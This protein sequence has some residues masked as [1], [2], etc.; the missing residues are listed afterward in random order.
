MSTLFKLQASVGPRDQLI[1]G[2][3]FEMGD[4]F[5]FVDPG[6]PS[7]ETPLHTVEIDTFLLANFESTNAQ[8][9]LFLQDGLR[10]HALRY[11]KGVVRMSA[12]TTIIC[13]THDYASY[14]SIGYT[15]DS[16]ALRDFRA[17]HPVVGVMWTGAALYC[18]WLSTQSKLDTCF[19]TKT[20]TCD[21]SKSGYRLPTE[22]E[23]EYAAR[24]AHTSPY[25]NYP[26]G[27]DRDV[28]K[29]NW[30]NS[31]DPYEIGELPYTT[32]VGFY[33]GSLRRR[34]EFMWLSNLESYQT[35][36]GS[37]SF[38]LF[39]MAGNV[40]EFVYDWYSQ[41]YYAKSPLRNP[42]GPVQGFIMPDGKA[43]RGMRGGNWYNGYTLDS[44]NDGHS[45]VSNRNPSYYRG[46]QDPIHPW[47]HVGFRVARRYTP[48][49]DIADLPDALDQSSQLTL[50]P[51]PS[52]SQLQLRLHL[53]KAETFQLRLF[54]E[55]GLC[56][57]VISE[58]NHPSKN[59]LLTT[60]VDELASGV[61]YCV[62]YTP[63]T[64]VCRKLLVAHP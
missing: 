4:H 1:P 45:R 27:N 38:G 58:E 59:M 32:P 6:H 31:G 19:D 44:I 52:N 24:G 8:F 10:R 37:N 13:F 35:H 18:N 14:C 7:D 39:D 56:V 25:Y 46:P 64:S 11:D 23:W 60:S 55:L 9:L 63:G 62:L 22:A 53:P 20:W 57:Q 21:F 50:E 26:W 33:D 61:Y 5:G 34:S 28:R 15:A 17:D 29:A 36:D 43:Y 54:N 42:T 30:P 40:W 51:N 49:T 41:D 12:D 2:G 47:Y 16:F 48:S 3:S